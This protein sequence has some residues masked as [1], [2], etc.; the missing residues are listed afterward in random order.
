MAAMAQNAAPI[1]NDILRDGIKA[2]ARVDGNQVVPVSV[3]RVVLGMAATI[4]GDKT[5]SIALTG[6]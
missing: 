5:D 1:M 4:A 6:L 2:S 3:F